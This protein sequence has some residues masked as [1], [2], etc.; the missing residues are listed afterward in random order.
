MNLGHRVKSVTLADYSA[1]E[2]EQ[3]LQGGN[4][5]R[6]LAC[7]VL[8]VFCSQLC[9]KDDPHG[10]RRQSFHHASLRGCAGQQICVCSPVV[11]RST[12]SAIS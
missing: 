12:W 3:M 10:P 4:Q 8:V 1:S 11:K 7:K 6:C 9:V 5:V 2:V